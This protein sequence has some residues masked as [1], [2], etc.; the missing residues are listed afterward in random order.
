MSR[1]TLSIVIPLLNEEEVIPELHKRLHSL[2]ESLDVTWEAIFIDDG[3]T[4]R[5][6][7]LLRALGASEPRYKL[8]VLS[9]NFGHQI[10]VTA[11]LD[12]A[13]GEAVVI[14]DADLQDPPECIREMLAKWREGYDVVYGVRTKREGDGLFKRATAAIFYRGMRL[15]VGLDLP[16]DTGDFRLTSRRVVLAMRTLRETHRFVRGFVVWVGFR[17]AAV[18]FVRTG[19]FAGTTKYPLRKMLRF[20]VDG[21]TSFSTV[22]LRLSSLLGGLSGLAAFAIALW[23]TWVHFF[24]KGAVPGWTSILLA[25]SLVSAAQFLMIGILGEYVGRIYEEVKRRPLYIVGDR[26]NFESTATEPQKGEP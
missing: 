12:H 4:D 17:H 11:G 3:S 9:R 23:S 1:P 15:L 5:S 10:A 25:M 8:I 14:I 7:D 26:Q 19:R 2:L 6:V 22:P 20:A 18:H 16:V 13:E 21:I 24:V